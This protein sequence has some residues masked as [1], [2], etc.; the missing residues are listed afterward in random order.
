MYPAHLEGPDKILYSCQ[1]LVE[2][3]ASIEYTLINKLADIL[4]ELNAVGK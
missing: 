4:P 2:L 3:K 1:D